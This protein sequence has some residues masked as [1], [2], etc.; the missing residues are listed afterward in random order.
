VNVDKVKAL[1]DSFDA[2]SEDERQAAKMVFD[3]MQSAVKAAAK[4]K[5]KKR[6]P[7]SDTGK[8]RGPLKALGSA[9]ALPEE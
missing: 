1:V 5:A 8:K 3:A 9:P 6:K 2:C 4:T 7:R